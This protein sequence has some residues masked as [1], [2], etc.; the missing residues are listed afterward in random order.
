MK[1][2]YRITKIFFAGKYPYLKRV[3]KGIKGS[4]F[5]ELQLLAPQ[6]I[7]DALNKYGDQNFIEVQNELFSPKQPKD[8]KL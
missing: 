3:H 6:M 5:R 2:Y 7:K 1:R 4:F 8:N